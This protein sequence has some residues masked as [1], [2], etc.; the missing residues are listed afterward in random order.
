MYIILSQVSI[1]R[2]F[3]YLTKISFLNKHIDPWPIKLP[4]NEL[5]FLLILSS[6][7]N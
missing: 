2:K 1:A 5:G 7:S 6:L 4:Q 3:V